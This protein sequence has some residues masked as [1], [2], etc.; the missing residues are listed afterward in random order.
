MT[1]FKQA[2]FLKGKKTDAHKI[3]ESGTFIEIRCEPR[4]LLLPRQSCPDIARPKA[5]KRQLARAT[6]KLYPNSTQKSSRNLL[7]PL[8]EVGL[9][10]TPCCQDGI[11][12]PARLPFRHSGLE[13][14]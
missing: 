5:S 3:R 7:K 12:N 14:R 10:P 8:P 11:L 1:D 13:L 2:G 6:H 9:E 4:S